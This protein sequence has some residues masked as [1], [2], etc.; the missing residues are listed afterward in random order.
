MKGKSSHFLGET[1][2]NQAFEML[3]VD[4]DGELSIDE[5]TAGLSQL[6]DRHTKKKRFNRGES[7]VD[8]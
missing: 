2:K 1:M 6:Q 4:E 8:T 7:P 3:D 5:F